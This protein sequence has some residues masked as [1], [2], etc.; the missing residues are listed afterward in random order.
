MNIEAF[1]VCEDYQPPKDYVPSMINPILDL[2]YGNFDFIIV[3][4]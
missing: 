4:T 1:I 3:A 2:H